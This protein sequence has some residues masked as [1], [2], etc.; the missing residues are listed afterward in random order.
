M[1][2]E[3]TLTNKRRLEAQR[4]DMAVVTYGVQIPL[5]NPPALRGREGGSRSA[6]LVKRLNKAPNL[7]VETIQLHPA[8]VKK[9][10][11]GWEHGIGV[12]VCGYDHTP[13]RWRQRWFLSTVV[14]YGVRPGVVV[15]VP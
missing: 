5:Q 12:V 7:W 10:K 15:K 6:V 9:I 2:S 11:A 13:V 3:T 1:I 8:T 14:C 4:V